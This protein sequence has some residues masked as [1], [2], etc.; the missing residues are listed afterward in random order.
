MSEIEAKLA[1]RGIP[2][3]V[4]DAVLAEAR[5]LGYLDD[6]ELAGQLARGFLARGYGRRR[7]GVA[8]RRRGLRPAAAE[9]ALDAMYGAVDELALA[10]QALGTRSVSD[11]TQQRRAVAFLVRRGFSSAVAWQVV[12][13]K[14]SSP[15]RGTTRPSTVS[16]Y[17]GMRDGWGLLP[18]ERVATL[19]RRGATVAGVH[20]PRPRRL[21]PPG[22]ACDDAAAA[23]FEGGTLVEVSRAGPTRV[24]TGSRRRAEPLEARRL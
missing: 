1:A 21:P 2:Q 16:R 13:G 10:E 24:R 18:G 8:L 23:L 11:A 19:R 20:E 15:A 4:A 12:R 6:E 3:E 17:S 5:A 7:A 9:A 14:G 22:I